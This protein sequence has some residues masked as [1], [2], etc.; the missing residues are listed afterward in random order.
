MDLGRGV[1]FQ[2]G[3][4]NLFD[5]SCFLIESYPEPG[6]PPYINLRYRF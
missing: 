4:G 2:A 1:H 6:G 3:V 5:R